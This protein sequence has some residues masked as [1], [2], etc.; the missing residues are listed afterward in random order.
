MNPASP[1]PSPPRSLSLSLSPPKK[2]RQF[3]ISAAPPHYR[4]AA[5][6][7]PSPR[8]RRHPV[9]QALRSNSPKRICLWTTDSVGIALLLC[10]RPHSSSP[11]FSALSPPP[12][13]LLVSVSSPCRV[14]AGAPS[15]FSRTAPP[16]IRRTP[17]ELPPTA[18]VVPLLWCLAGPA[19]VAPKTASPP[20]CYPCPCPAP[21]S[22]PLPVAS[23]SCKPPGAPLCCRFMIGTVHP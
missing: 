4:F 22:P 1:L 21:S 12:V 8:H 18:S 7:I 6:V 9:F 20:Q 13:L 16:P 5:P 3:S 14:L 17:V 19:T 23:L 15:L 10:L 11:P 2:T